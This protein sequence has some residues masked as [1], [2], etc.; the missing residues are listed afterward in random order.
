MQPSPHQSAA[1]SCPTLA[2]CPRRGIRSHCTTRK[3]PREDQAWPNQPAAP[4]R[5]Q[6]CLFGEVVV[7]SCRLGV[8]ARS[9]SRVVRRLGLLRFKP[10]AVSAFRA[11]DGSVQFTEA[12]LAP[13][14]RPGI[15]QHDPAVIAAHAAQRA[16]N[17]AVVIILGYVPRRTAVADWPRVV[18]FHHVTAVDARSGLRTSRWSQ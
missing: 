16:V 6:P 11:F 5:A 3:R 12:V 7:F 13:L 17:R 8:R 9:V 1:E 14:A 10:P 18:G 4:N 15:G 2:R